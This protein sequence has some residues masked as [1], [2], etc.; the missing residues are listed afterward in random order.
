MG[1][2]IRLARLLK[3]W[4]LELGLLLN[5]QLQSPIW[6][7]VG[8]VV[9]LLL[10]LAWGQ[11]HREPHGCIIEVLIAV[12]P[13]GEWTDVHYSCFKRE[14]RAAAVEFAQAVRLQL[15]YLHDPRG[16]TS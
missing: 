7:G 3:E 2:F 14:R 15:L 16:N 11:A 4:Y 9:L 1:H 12:P 6:E 5:S 10:D 8:G 13:L